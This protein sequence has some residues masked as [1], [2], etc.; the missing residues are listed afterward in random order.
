VTKATEDFSPAHL[1]ERYFLPFYPAEARADLTWSR[2]TGSRIQRGESG[3][4]RPPAAQ[5]GRERGGRRL[6]GFQYL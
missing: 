2:R 1:F 6:V 4:P 3:T 5:R